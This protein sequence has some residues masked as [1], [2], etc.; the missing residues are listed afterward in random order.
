MLDKYAGKKFSILGD[1][2][3]TLKGAV[4]KS[5]KV[6][7]KNDKSK[8]SG[9]F[10][11]DDTWWG[12]VIN[13]LGGELLVNNSWS[14]SWVAKMP[15]ISSLFP[16]ACSDK[17]AKGLHKG[18]E[19]PDVVIVYMGNNDWEHGVNPNN[20]GTENDVKSFE[21]AY[22][23]MLGKIKT[24][25]PNAEIWCCTICTS[26]MSANPSYPFKYYY[27]GWHCEDFNKVIR[28]LAN[29]ND[30]RLIDLYSFNTPYDSID[31]EHPTRSGMKTI[32]SMVLQ[33][34]G[35]SLYADVEQYIIENYAEFEPAITSAPCIERQIDFDAF[36]GQECLPTQAPNEDSFNTYDICEAQVC[37]PT[38]ASS[39]A[40]ASSDFFK[41]SSPT[42]D[43][44]GI[45]D[46]LDESFSEMLLRKI[47]ELGMTDAQCYKKAHID[48]KLFSKIRSN[49]NY[50]PS[51]P[52]VISFCIALE[53]NLDETNEMLLKAGFALSHSN[54]FDV[55]IEYFIKNKNYNIFEIN[56]AL[57]AFDQ[58]LL[59]A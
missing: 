8:K 32:A 42:T 33:S 47:D 12:T 25:Y 38:P 6:F 51:K 4:P 30:C 31:G 19:M 55:I 5:Y 26:F 57:F 15:I 29:A 40:E 52:T 2:I 1:S 53:L 56:D 48:R 17:R 23:I 7:Y 34:V 10:T 18:D 24:A 21:G 50:K 13:S 36:E 49:P 20:A 45:F 11:V 14:G 54:K 37:A 58:S 46:M 27:G 41:D 16:S 3:S 44:S 59:G 28:K 9:V 35:T 43:F 39:S 22:E